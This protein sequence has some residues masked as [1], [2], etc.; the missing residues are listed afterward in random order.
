M[1]KNYV[2]QMAVEELHESDGC[3]EKLHE[4]DG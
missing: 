4:L 2:S 1:C 3:A